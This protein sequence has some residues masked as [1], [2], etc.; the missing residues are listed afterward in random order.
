MSYSRIE[1]CFLCL[2]LKHAPPP[3]QRI[4][5][6]LLTDHHVVLLKTSD[7]GGKAKQTLQKCG[8]QKVSFAGAAPQVS[9]QFNPSV[10]TQQSYPA[11]CLPRCS[12]GSIRGTAEQSLAVAQV[13]VPPCLPFQPQ[14]PLFPFPECFI[15]PL[16]SLT[17]Q[18][19]INT[20]MNTILHV[21]SVDKREDRSVAYQ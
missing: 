3:P 17:R 12:W 6:S 7:G 20:E 15:N 1:T 11:W 13:W 21:Q 10:S 8:K 4:H 16:Q 2:G 19:I 18:L 14:K 5:P 9:L